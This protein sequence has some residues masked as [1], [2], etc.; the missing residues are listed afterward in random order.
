MAPYILN[1][2]NK[3]MLSAS[4]LPERYGISSTLFYRRRKYLQ[5]LGYTLEPLKEGSK[6]LYDLEHIEL[7][8]EL[9]FYIQENGRQRGFPTPAEQQPEVPLSPRTAETSNPDL[10]F[11]LTGTIE[12]EEDADYLTCVD[13]TKFRLKKMASFGQGGEGTWEFIPSTD[14]NGK[15]TSLT[16]G[17]KGDPTQGDKCSL[18][19]RVLQ[20]SK[21]V[22]LLQVNRPKQKPLKIS[23]IS[24]DL[25]MKPGEL[26]EIEAS[27]EGEVLVLQTGDLLESEGTKGKSDRKKQQQTGNKANTELAIAT[28]KEKTSIT[29]W[30]LQPPR[31]HDY[32]WEWNCYSPSTNTKARVWVEGTEVTIYHYNTPTAAP[33]VRD[34]EIAERLT[35]TPLGAV[36]GVG[37]SCFQVC[38]GPYEVVLDCGIHLRERDPFPALEFLKKPDLL[39][40]S[41]AHLDHIGALP[42]F[43]HR[44]PKA[45]IITT[46]AT[47]EIARVILKDGLQ[48]QQNEDCPKLFDLENLEQAIFHLETEGVGENFEP[49]P[50][51]QV[52]FI[53]AG[54]IPGAVCIYLQYGGQTLLYTGDFHTSNSRTTTGLKL[55]DLPNADILITETVN[56]NVTHPSRKTQEKEL[57]QAIWEVVQGGGNVLIPAF[58]LGRGQEIL[59]A[60]RMASQLP[61]LKVPIYV[62]GLL[63]EVTKVLDKNVR[64][65]PESLQNF[66]GQNG[67]KP[68]FASHGNARIR[69]VAD[70]EE[71]PFAIT[72]PSIILA[73]S[74]MLKEV[75]SVY[76]AQELLKKE[77]TT[78]FICNC[79]DEE[80]PGGV[81]EEIKTGDWIQLESDKV[82][83]KAQ[84]KRFN[85]STH[86]DRVGL[87]Q[88]IGK[89]NP[90]HLILIKGTPDAVHELA[91]SGQN[92]SKYYIHIPKIGDTIKYG[93]AP[94]YLDQKKIA[95]LE[96][97]QEFELHLETFGDDAW[98]R[99]PREVVEE[100]PRWENLAV[101][102]VMRAKW[103]GFYLRLS[104]IA[105]EKL[106]KESNI[107]KAKV[108]GGE[109][110]AVCQFFHRGKC[111]SDHS[112]LD[113]RHV[114]PTGYCPEFQPED[115]I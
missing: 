88:V 100:D 61:Q 85:L 57:L 38:I 63:A 81:L 2:N 59:L 105:P 107:K 36:F 18:R 99:V 4:E 23:L 30:K 77:T 25:G 72:Q 109:C 65:L 113:R 55:A 114:D 110:C 12:S 29:D 31:Q 11:V 53:N 108:T 49:L 98:L 92:S 64:L 32:Y 74:G 62:D 9:H 87:G 111:T 35:V 15:I 33:V 90:K 101:S 54:H 28:L 91:R 68:F 73:S 5:T 47:R 7:F 89:V 115:M 50:G 6:S 1:S 58:P 51:L 78:L 21:K 13:N 43:R 79:A 19:G 82:Q 104:P 42:I 26:W 83:V 3:L 80:Y 17:K 60:L 71:R 93:Q 70:A 34:T 67:G 94:E 69:A 96:Q 103:D 86:A 75:A 48:W 20:V 39:L 27:R 40:L 46:V 41:H 45:K 16:Q 8:D 24:K 44:F 84:I 22:V 56:G 14:S 76:Y 52:R 66:A 106:L 102:G 112:P 37:A 10:S 95:V 97:P